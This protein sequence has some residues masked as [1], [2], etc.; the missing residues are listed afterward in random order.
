V[1]VAGGLAGRQGPGPFRHPGHSGPGPGPSG[2]RDC[3]GPQLPQQ[4]GLPG[5]PQA[6][7]NHSCKNAGG[8][9]PR[10]RL[11]IKLKIF[12]FRFDALGDFYCCSI[13]KNCCSHCLFLHFKYKG[14]RKLSSAGTAM[15][16]LTVP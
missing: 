10:I 15:S 4:E 13:N 1:S 6:A 16:R 5:V 3:G 12:P 8:G 2:P 9:G 11:N 7:R 14:I